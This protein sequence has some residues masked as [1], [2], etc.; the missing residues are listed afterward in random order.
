[1][2]HFTSDRERRLWFWAL[3]VV[4]AIYS[5]LGLAGTLADVLRNQNLLGVSFALGFLMV[6]LAVVGSAL[7]R[8]AGRREMWVLLGVTAVYV[9]VLVRMGVTAEERTHL[10]EYG[11]VAVLIHQALTE[12]RRNG[13]TV[14]M[15]AVLTV[16]VT[17]LLGWIDEG[18]Q[19]TLPNRV[20][21][22]RDV[23]VNALAGLMAVAASLG[24]ARARRWDLFSRG[25]SADPG[26][27]DR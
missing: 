3:A 10:F 12:R 23:G 18:I 6:I 22:I 7:K 2:S 20:Y 17:A 1:M 27:A 5:T 11:V 9:M 8:R 4:V 26:A 16:A 13:R 15:P 14:P 21:D 25:S 24:I 19:G